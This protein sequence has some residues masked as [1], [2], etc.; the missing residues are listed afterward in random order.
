MAT[1][2]GQELID[3]LVAITAAIKDGNEQQIEHREDLAAHQRSFAK[4]SSSAGKQY[5][6][7]QSGLLKSI[8][9]N[10]SLPLPGGARLFGLSSF[11]DK[12]GETTKQFQKGQEAQT[13][14]KEFKWRPP[15][16]SG[17]FT[18]QSEAR[19]AAAAK[20]KGLTPQQKKRSPGRKPEEIEKRLKNQLTRCLRVR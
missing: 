12:I 2:E 15:D 3:A 7:Q 10:I 18:E 8:V 11:M 5:N 16:A 6:K 17:R 19:K 9:Q 4:S 1:P 13:A 20:W 14:Y